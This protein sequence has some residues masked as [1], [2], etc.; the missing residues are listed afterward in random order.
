MTNEEKILVRK[1]YADAEYAF[2]K[3]IPTDTPDAIIEAVFAKMM[4]T[5]SNDLAKW[6]LEKEN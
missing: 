4:T 6:I 3:A 5:L 2:V 1:I